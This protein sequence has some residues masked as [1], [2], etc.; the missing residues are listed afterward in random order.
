MK[1]TIKPIDRKAVRKQL[2][3]IPADQLLAR[4]DQALKAHA[5]ATLAAE[6]GSA[7]RKPAA[8]RQ[9]N[10]QKHDAGWLSLELYYQCLKHGLITTQSIDPLS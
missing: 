5:D 9:M 3:T 1:P 2:R 8:Q 10:I 7:N 6:Y 4:Y